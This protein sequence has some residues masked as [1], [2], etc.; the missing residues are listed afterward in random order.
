MNKKNKSLKVV[1]IGSGIGGLTSAIACAHAGFNVEIYERARKLR[2]AG[3][4]I[5]LWPNGGKVLK[6]YNLG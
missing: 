4:G 2:P 6:A 5:T 3:G 1:I